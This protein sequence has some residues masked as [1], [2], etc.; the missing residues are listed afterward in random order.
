MAGAADSQSVVRRL[1][2]AKAALADITD[3]ARRE[4][5]EA[6]EVAH[7]ETLIRKV[8]LTTASAATLTSAAQ[9]AGFSDDAE[10]RLLWAIAERVPPGRAT[11]RTMPTQKKF[12]GPTQ[13]SSGGCC[14]S[15]ACR[16]S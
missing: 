7:V 13:S 14:E 5:V 15:S 11:L 8:R 2:K 6:D 4:V 3:N 1:E 16:T 10:G 9:E 12:S